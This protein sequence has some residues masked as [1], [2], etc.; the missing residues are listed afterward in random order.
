MADD[1]TAKR[2]SGIKSVLLGLFILFQLIYLPLSNLVQLVPREIPPQKSGLDIRVQRD[3]RITENRVM[4]NAVNTVGTAID[5]YGQLSGQVQAWSLFAPDFGTQTIHPVV[6]FEFFDGT[7]R[8]LMCSDSPNLRVDPDNYFRWPGSHSR[9]V[10]YEFL[11]CVVYWGFNEDSLQQHGPAW[12]DAIRRHVL[13]IQKPLLAYFRLNLAMLKKAHPDLPQPRSATLK[14]SIHPSPA[15]GQRERPPPFT[16]LLARW[17]PDRKD[18]P[19]Y[20]PV[21]A[22]DPVARTFA[23]IER[24]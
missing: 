4:Q 18:D 15:P 17:N 21:E 5:R 8:Y 23:P 1:I 6:E 19:T 13:R 14:V 7:D 9:M 10:G 20:L 24:D 16:M 12:R 11:L 2:S 3:G 22:F